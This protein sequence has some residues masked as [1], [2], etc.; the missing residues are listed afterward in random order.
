MLTIINAITTIFIVAALG[1]FVKYFKMLPENAGAAIGAY[2][3]RLA[4]PCLFIHVL[5]NASLEQL[6]AY[7]YWIALIT[8]PLFIY[9]IGYFFDL[10]YF[11]RG[12]GVAII[13]ALSCTCSN[14][15]F[16]GLPFLYNLFPNNPE[17]LLIGGI[18]CLSP[19]LMLAFGQTHLQFVHLKESESGHK[20]DLYYFWTLFNNLILKNP[21]LMGIIIGLLLSST[22][23][24]IWQPLDNALSLLGS[25][26]APCALVVLG[27]DFKNNFQRATHSTTVSLKGMTI[28]QSYIAIM[29][30]I[31]HPLL[32]WGMMIL[33]DVNELWAAVSVITSSSAT[34]I[35]LYVVA[36]NYGYMPEQCALSVAITNSICLITMGTFS[37]MFI[38][39]M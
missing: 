13:T 39:L 26:S 7:T 6:S 15:A 20:F 11:K 36:E 35:G 21:L 3:M 32:V 5:A 16:L 25:S 12:K 28:H 22:G 9:L 27:L 31:I 10:F 1:A 4:L 2:V 29:K 8:P 30:L 14:A 17:A 18:S 19:S 37:Y 33:L 34:G 23:I 24:G 38:G